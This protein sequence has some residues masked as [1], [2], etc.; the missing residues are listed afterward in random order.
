MAGNY[1]WSEINIIIWSWNI[2]KKKLL[3]N[4]PNQRTK[5]RAKNWVEINDD[6]QGTYN[7]NSQIKFKLLMLKSSFCDCSDAYKLVKGTITVRI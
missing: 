6:A 3:E 7:T 1:S 4:A 5:F 2:K